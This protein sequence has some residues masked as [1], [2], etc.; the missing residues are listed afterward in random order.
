MTI[1]I[2]NN[3]FYYL[4]RPLDNRLLDAANRLDP[5]PLHKF[6]WGETCSVGKERFYEYEM[7]PSFLFWAR[8]F[9]KDLG[10]FV[11][12][13]ITDIW[14]NTYRR[15]SYQEPHDH[16]YSDLSVVI[17]LDDLIPEDGGRFY[18]VNRHSSELG[19][20][21]ISILGQE[22][23]IHYV[24]YKKGD[25]IP[26]PSYMMHGVTPYNIS[27]WEDNIQKKRRTT[28]AFNLDISNIGPFKGSMAEK[29]YEEAMRIE[30]NK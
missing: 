28:V 4:V 9:M 19:R 15:G 25:M 20:K 18:F 13:G 2:F 10:K 6:S 24:D 21:W 26:F 16:P 23:E 11:D 7:I 14:K 22:G 8:E 27:W 12:M 30:F 1:K 3:S 5:H 29:L 17:F